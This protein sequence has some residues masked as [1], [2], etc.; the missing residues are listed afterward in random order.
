MRPTAFLTSNRAQV[1]LPMPTAPI[2]PD[3]G[4]IPAE[5]RTD[6]RRPWQRTWF[7]PL[8][9]F[10]IVFAVDEGSPNGMESDSVGAVPT[11]VSMVMYHT[12][13]L[14]HFRGHLV[15]RIALV[16]SHGHIYPFYPWVTSLFAVP[17]VLADLVLNKIGI[18]SGPLGLLRFTNNWEMQAFSMAVVVAATS[19]VIYWTAMRVLTLDE[20]RRRRW[21]FGV[22]LGF[23]FTTPAWSTASRSMWD[24]GPS[25][26]C[27]SVALLCALRARE[28]L[29]G[30]TGMGLALGMAYTVRPTDSL[31]V[32]ILGLW[33]LGWHRRGFL[34]VVG[35][36]L[37]PLCVFVIVNLSTYHQ[38]LPPYFAQDQSFRITPSYFDA[39]AADL[40]SPG[41]GLLVYVPLVGLSVAGVV[42]LRRS[43]SL[44]PFWIAVT[45]VP[46]ALLLLLASFKVWWAG[47]AYGPR[48]F[49]DVMPFFVL[50]ALPAVDHIAQHRFERNS[51]VV[52]VVSIAFVWSLF[53]EVQGATLRS[54]WCWNVEPVSINAHPNNAWNWADPQFLR[55]IRVLIWGPDRS[56]EVV[57]AGVITIGCPV[58]S[59]RP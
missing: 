46:V 52:A 41:R 50:L 37:I 45:I 38:V 43:H 58:E 19:V 17:W 48:F 4:A 5:S 29:P 47:D 12:I 23:A 8:V 51:L 36:A 16:S 34:R 3:P 42:I 49:T 20:P 11:A 9:L 39:F 33:V 27:L 32:I 31:P 59:V 25:M 53:V 35:G 56:S 44:S 2:R 13:N 26:L 40:V 14:D 21:A 55:G 6:R 15:A 24:H 10:A 54:S 1:P 28:G 22:A 30:F 7:W 57:R 18:G